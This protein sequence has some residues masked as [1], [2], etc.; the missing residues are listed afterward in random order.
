LDR[1][2]CNMAAQRDQILY[3]D[4]CGISFL[5]P[6]EAQRQESPKPLHCPGCRHALP[7][8]ERERGLVKWYNGRK[9]FGFIVRA[10][11]PEIFAHRNEIQG[12][13]RLQPG[14]LVEFSVGESPK[15]PVARKIRVLQR[16]KD[17]PDELKLP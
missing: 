7:A 8:R 12:S 14:D 2:K 17:A 11:A 13:K 16:A 10:D 6:Q 15:G 3:C 4:R 1:S 9:H 5:W